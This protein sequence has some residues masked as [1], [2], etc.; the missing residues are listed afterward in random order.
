MGPGMIRGELDDL[1]L[2]ELVQL[3]GSQR[4]SAQVTVTWA[5]GRGDL[6]FKNGRVCHVEVGELT[7]EEA[8]GKLIAIEEGI[9]E[10]LKNGVPPV[11]T[12]D[13]EWGSLLFE[14][15]RAME[16]G[17]YEIK[18]LSQ[19]MEERIGGVDPEGDGSVLGFGIYDE[20]RLAYEWYNESTTFQ[21][22][23]VPEMADLAGAIGASIGSGPSSISVIKDDLQ[24]I[25]VFLGRFRVIVYSSPDSRVEMNFLS[26]VELE[27]ALK[28]SGQ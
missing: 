11:E 12:M 15:L 8:F 1:S 28:E 18:V 21:T 4:K 13:E 2:P 7:G 19:Y 27:G 3:Y 5:S 14:A 10:I 26:K 25:A 9:F 22:L 23:P 17:D 16:E 24:A 20:E 6:Y